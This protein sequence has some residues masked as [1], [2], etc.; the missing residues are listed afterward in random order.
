MHKLQAKKDGIMLQISAARK[1]KKDG[2]TLNIGDD[3]ILVSAC[4]GWAT[5]P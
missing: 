3:V 5:P 1:P 2:L 4:G